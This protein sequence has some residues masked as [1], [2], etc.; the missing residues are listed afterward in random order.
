MSD[1]ERGEGEGAVAA[2]EA[3]GGADVVLVGAVEA[4]DELLERAELGRDS[5]EVFEAN[6]LVQRKRGS[7][8]GAVSVE[9]VHAGLIGRIAVGDEAEGAIFGQR[10]SRL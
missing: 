5:V 2:G 1:K 6:D 4:F 9:E 3:A 7:G 8:S 10:A